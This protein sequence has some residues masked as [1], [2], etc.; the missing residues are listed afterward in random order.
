VSKQAIAP[1]VNL[2]GLIALRD[3]LCQTSPEALLGKDFY[4]ITDFFQLEAL[5]S[6]AYRVSALNFSITG[7]E[8]PLFL[9][10]LSFPDV[11]VVS[12]NTCFITLG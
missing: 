1:S 7:R 12:C 10:F 5:P 9:A 2:T 3:L 6:K 11:V 8:E 4:K